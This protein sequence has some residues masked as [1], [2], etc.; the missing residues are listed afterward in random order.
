MLESS[1]IQFIINDILSTGEYSLKGIACYTGSF[2]DVIV[3]LLTGVNK[4]PS[5]FFLRKLIDLHRSTRRDI[6]DLIMK[7]II[8]KVRIEIDGEEKSDG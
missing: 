4:Y 7:R 1:I 6:Y 3:E 8:A 5:A 2:E